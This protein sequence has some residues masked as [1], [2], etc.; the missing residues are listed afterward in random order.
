MIGP[1]LHQKLGNEDVTC[2]AANTLSEFPNGSRVEVAVLLGDFFK[3]EINKGLVGGAN[4]FVIGTPG[5]DS[6]MVF[7]SEEVLEKDHVGRIEGCVDHSLEADVLVQP[8]R[9]AQA[10]L[11]VYIKLI[12]EDLVADLVDS[13]GLFPIILLASVDWTPLAVPDAKST[14]IHPLTLLLI[15]PPQ[16]TLLF[17]ST[18]VNL[19][20]TGETEEGVIV[21][22]VTGV[23]P[24]LVRITEVREVGCKGVAI[25]EDDV[26][27]I[28]GTDG[29]VNFIVELHNASVFG[30]GG[31]VEGVVAGDPL[32]ALVVLGELSPEPKDALLVVSVVPEIG[33]V[34]TMIRMPVSV[35]TTGGGMKI[36]DGVDAVLR[37]DVD[38]TIQVLET[39]LL[40]DAGVH[41][42]LKV[43]VVES[44]TDAVQT[45][46]LEEFG[47]GVLEEVLQEF[48][49]K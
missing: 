14:L 36:E 37:T 21:D 4:I 32:V 10:I 26:I 38:D 30:V 46:A 28:L 49:E 27:G 33:D 5:I 41:V 6:E 9:P 39:R 18:S 13:I 8:D 29:S 15:T 43:T 7:L 19:G 11:S 1:L 2:Q 17:G 20:G 42:I 44:N 3:D 48:I 24:V 31:F 22:G 45:K 47:I 25:K 23:I 40:E 34:A 12:L 35:L 16:T